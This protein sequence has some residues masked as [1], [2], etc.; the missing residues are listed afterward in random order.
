M[1]K[2]FLCGGGG[3]RPGVYLATIV[4]FIQK[5]ICPKHRVRMS[6]V[7][8]ICRRN[9]SQVVDYLMRSSFALLPR[10]NFDIKLESI[11]F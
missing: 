3:E 8:N 10:D 5:S 7:S 6:Y 4:H 1:S 9:A 11:A 2:T